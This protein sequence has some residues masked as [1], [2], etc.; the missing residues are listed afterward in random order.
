MSAVTSLHHVYINYVLYLV[1][2]VFSRGHCNLVLRCNA[3]YPE[4]HKRQGSMILL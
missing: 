1:K 4:T 3:F 2:L